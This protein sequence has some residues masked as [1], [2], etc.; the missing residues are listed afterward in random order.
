MSGLM[1]GLIKSAGAIAKR[2]LL[3]AGLLTSITAS[4][5][6]IP[7]TCTCLW[8]GSFTEVASD[9]DLVLRGEVISRKGN[10]VDI[11]PITQFQGQ[12]WLD[13]IRVWMR[14]GDYCRPAA[15]AFEPG[16]Q[17]VFALHQI[18][19]VPE[20]GFDPSTPNQSF[21]RRLDYRLSA[22]G[23]YWLKMR[24]ETVIG[25]LLPGTPRW[26]HEPDMTPVVIDLLAAYLAGEASVEDLRD[27]AT[28]DPELRALRLNTRS[29][30]RGQ[31]GLLEAS[32][33]EP[34]GD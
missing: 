7:E 29:F 10:A 25:N 5:Q 16:S 21:G 26:N 3:A 15:E 14:T 17:W 22:C 30:L 24:G 18:Q 34:E 4:A 12:T 2:W 19:S 31:D 28:E 8:Q 13:S 6:E 1:W 20:N 33:E 32:P 23:G 9:T 11:A 27:A